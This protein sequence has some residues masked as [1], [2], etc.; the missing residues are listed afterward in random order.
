V[1]LGVLLPMVVLGIMGLAL[2]IRVLRPTPPLRF[3]SPEVARNIWD[4]RNPDDPACDVQ[5]DAAESAALITTRTGAGLLWSMG[6]DPVA[7]RFQ[8]RCVC[9]ETRTGLV[10]KT[11]DFTAPK[12]R[13]VLPDRDVRRRWCQI[14]EGQ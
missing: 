7:R 5:L 3:S 9:V 11:G 1:P 13:L 12:I 6:A 4:R 8:S 14:L 10:V 2:L